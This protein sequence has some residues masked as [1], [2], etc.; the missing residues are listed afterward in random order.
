[1]RPRCRLGIAAVAARLENGTLKVLAGA[2]PNLLREASLYRYSD[3]PVDQRSETPVDA[4]NH[5]LA[6][7]RYM[8]TKIDEH[9]LARVAKK[10]DGEPEV[11]KEERLRRR[12][13]KWLSYRNEALWRRIF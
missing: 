8:V 6:A 5:A 2:C 4:H 11:D 12:Q 13:K 3:D 1:L 9:Q 10:T 7:L